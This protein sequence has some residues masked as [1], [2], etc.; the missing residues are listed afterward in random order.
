M[1][2]KEDSKKAEQCWT[3]SEFTKQENNDNFKKRV[4]VVDWW[5][6]RGEA[7]LLMEWRADLM[8]SISLPKRDSPLLVTTLIAFQMGGICFVLLISDW[9]VDQLFELK[10]K[11]FL[12][13]YTGQD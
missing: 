10:N 1:D 12:L 13:G 8:K 7:Q 5:K 3:T 6:V 2:I 9:S 4:H 11:G